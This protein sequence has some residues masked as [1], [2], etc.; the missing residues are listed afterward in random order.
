V[1][2]FFHVIDYVNLNNQQAGNQQKACRLQHQYGKAV[3]FLKTKGGIKPLAIS[4]SL[5]TDDC[6]FL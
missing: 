2:E 1:Y 3:Y 4:D 6:H 5:D